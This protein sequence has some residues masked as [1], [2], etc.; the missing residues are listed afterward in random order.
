MTNETLVELAKIVLTNKIFQFNEKTTKQLKGT[1]IGTYFAASYV[2][3][4]LILIDVELQP[5]IWRRYIDDMFFIWEPGE[6][7]L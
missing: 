5:Y 4:E 2:I 1:V 6:D 3:E 7:F